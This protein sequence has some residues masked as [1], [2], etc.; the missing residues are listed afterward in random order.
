GADS[1]IDSGRLALADVFKRKVH[2]SVAEDQSNKGIIVE[3]RNG[4]DKSGSDKDDERIQQLLPYRPHYRRNFILPG[5]EYPVPVLAFVSIDLQ[6]NFGG[7]V[8]EI[9]CSAAGGILRPGER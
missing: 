2:V 6:V 7:K 5:S 1:V 4:T 9:R 8:V 3:G